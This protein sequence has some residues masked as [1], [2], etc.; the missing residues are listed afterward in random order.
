M[1]HGS[2]GLAGAVSFRTIEPDDFLSEKQRFGG[3][4]RSGYSSLDRSWFSSGAVAWQ[5]GDVRN[6]VFV[7][8][9]TGHEVANQGD[10]A[11]ADSRRANRILPIPAAAI[12]WQ[13]A[14]G[15]RMHNTGSE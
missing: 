2:D 15:K 4:L 13:K 10:D 12:C 11:S 3:F 5:A 8:R 9:R 1:Q 6:L 7:S 14:S